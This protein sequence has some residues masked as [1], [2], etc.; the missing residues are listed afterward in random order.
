MSPQMSQVRSRDVQS[1]LL[2]VR[3]LQGTSW[4][5]Q[6]GQELHF[7]HNSH[8]SPF[9]RQ[10][11]ANQL[12]GVCWGQHPTGNSSACLLGRAGSWVG[13]SGWKSSPDVTGQV[14][15]KRYREEANM[16]GGF[17]RIIAGELGGIFLPLLSLESNCCA[18]C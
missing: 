2:G 15:I 3:V 9:C 1:S 16:F 17:Y 12:P 7:T 6:G 5:P 8:S 10:C 13:N 14:P 18:A 11:S 4:G